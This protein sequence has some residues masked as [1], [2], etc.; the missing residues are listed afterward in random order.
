MAE[1]NA[2]ANPANPALPAIVPGLMDQMDNLP[3]KLA[4]PQGDPPDPAEPDVIWTD[5]DATPLTLMEKSMR[6]VP[7]LILMSLIGATARIKTLANNALARRLGGSFIRQSLGDYADQTLALGTME[8]TR[9]NDSNLDLIKAPTFGNVRILSSKNRKDFSMGTNNARLS[10]IN[11]PTSYEIARSIFSVAK[12]IIENGRLSAE[13]GFELIE[14][15]FG[16]ELSDTL[17]QYQ[18]QQKYS[19]FSHLI[20]TLVLPVSSGSALT[21]QLYQLL[22]IRPE[23]SK[24]GMIVNS[25]ISIH[26]RLAALVPSRDRESVFEAAGKNSLMTLTLLWWPNQVHEVENR[27]K[28]LETQSRTEMATA[29]QAGRLAEAEDIKRS[30]CPVAALGES[31]V[32]TLRHIEAALSLNMTMEQN[33]PA[34][35]QE[36][37]IFGRP[38]KNKVEAHN[39][40][41][42]EAHYHPQGATSLLGSPTMAGPA[43]DDITRSVQTM[44]IGPHTVATVSA[45]AP[46]LLPPSQ[47]GHSAALQPMQAPPGQSQD[48]DDD[49]RD[50]AASQVLHALAFGSSTQQ[51]PQFQPRLP[52]MASPPPRIPASAPPIGGGPAHPFGPP[53]QLP[54][55]LA[56]EVMANLGI[57]NGVI[58]QPMRPK[59]AKPKCPL[60]YNHNLWD[61]NGQL[62]TCFRYPNLS[63][64]ET[65]HICDTCG[66]YHPTAK[67]TNH[68]PLNQL[69]QG[70][71]AAEDPRAN[72]AN[73]P[74]PYTNQQPPQLHPP[75]K[76]NQD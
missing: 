51:R 21:R 53:V 49:L 10:K 33:M 48:S 44:G 64:E 29:V 34:K 72:R 45:G 65:G 43:I 57:G 32:L 39:L 19:A 41:L 1:Q 3:L 17:R 38:Y 69:M 36:K 14:H 37:N 66:N 75:Q 63:A 47:L 15:S 23:T 71:N 52:N 31:V 5:A 61:R 42:G 58:P 55:R 12:G 62:N 73:Q 25:I 46:A 16:G 20:Q 11:D 60:C 74:W 7:W 70:R 59:P 22:H 68:I 67:C 24:L 40:G 8:K 30:W 76:R 27:F 28:S 54:R 4:D 56:P 13:A 6:E 50:E 2:D 18:H 35:P 26:R 9:D